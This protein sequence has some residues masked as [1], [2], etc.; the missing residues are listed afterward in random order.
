MAQLHELNRANSPTL[1]FDGDCAFCRAAI[2]RWRQA[3][4]NRIQFAPYQEAAGQFPQIELAEFKRAAQYVDSS[5]KV[6]RGAGAFFQAAAYCGR[7]R[8]VLWL[9]EQVPPFAWGADA[10]YR[11]VAANRGPLA[12]WRRIWWGKDLKPPKYHIAS[13]VFLRLLGVIYF[14]AFVSLWTQI[15]GLIGDSG[16]L[17]VNKFLSAVDQFFAQQVPRGSAVWN[18]PT[19]VWI[20]PH[21]AF[22][23]LLCGAG[24]VL[25]LLLI[26]G[27]LPMFALV[28]LWL[29][30]LSLF[31]AGQVFL[32][33]Q[34]DSL[35]LETGFL[36]M[37]LAPF[38]VRSKFLA[39][40]HPPRVAVWLLWWLLFRLMLESGWVKLTWNRWRLG[41]NGLP[42]PNTWASLTALDFHY[43]T[44]P[45]PVWTSWYAA[46]LPE[47]FQKFSTVFLFIVE[48]GL[49]WLMLGP[50]YLK[51]VASG[52]IMLLMLLIAFT[53]NYNFFNLL[54]I[55]LAIMLLDDKAWPKFLQRRI[56]GAD[57]PVLASPTRWRSW[58]LI[59]FAGLALYVGTIQ[60]AEAIMPLEHRQPSLL[61]DWNIAQFCLVNE[62][63]LFRQM[64]ETR[65]EII[66]EGSDDGLAWKEYPFRWKAGDVSQRPGFC[67]PH[68]PRLDWQMWFEALDLEQAHTIT[69]TIDQRDMSPWFQ[70]FLMK[71]L[72]GEPSVVELLAKNPFPN[73]PPKDIRITLYEYRFTS[74]DERKNT[75][76]WWARESIWVGPS[77]ALR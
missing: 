58:M 75:G 14:I 74:A 16:I 71:L 51:Y 73:G 4:G 57:W 68:Q 65:P 70:S 77:M 7:K 27:I 42:V 38:V 36:A 17:P 23:H 26:C 62:Y 69:G 64:T 20:S 55:A 15:D 3:L 66:I 28:L 29:D 22:L 40:R 8:W 5:G 9:Y 24:A 60:V 63:G 18:V 52:G 11:L 72:R 31:Y 45:L 56:R 41:P 44:Q 6:S 37:F 10:V 61:A 46:K 12:V 34:W 21:D 48:L 50:R 39:N 2:D 35:L 47:W 25:S 53:G 76:D 19:L 32:S 67:E 33:F 54:T 43:W 1:I 59:P 30:Y 13:T 49:P